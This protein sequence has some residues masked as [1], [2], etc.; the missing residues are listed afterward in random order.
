M[1]HMRDF[2]VGDRVSVSGSWTTAEPEVFKGMVTKMLTANTMNVKGDDGATRKAVASI[3][4]TMLK[5][6]ARP[7]Q[8][9]LG[10][11]FAL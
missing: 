1:G 11:G 6:A 2:A 7:Q 9:A 5:Q 4:V 8:A 10:E 3:H